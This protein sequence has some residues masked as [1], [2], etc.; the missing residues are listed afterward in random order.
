MISFLQLIVHKDAKIM[1]I[2][3][4]A[5]HHIGTQTKIDVLNVWVMQ[6]V[7]I[8]VV[9][10]VVIYI[11]RCDS[12]NL[13]STTCQCGNGD[14]NT[15]ATIFPGQEYQFAPDATMYPQPTHTNLAN[16]MTSYTRLLYREPDR[17]MQPWTIK[18]IKVNTTVTQVLQRLYNHPTRSLLT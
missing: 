7:L 14:G 12:C 16:R 15:G 3:V 6:I 2:Y 13:Y 8:L 4:V 17:F 11:R 1:L 5:V 10:I 18:V 9:V